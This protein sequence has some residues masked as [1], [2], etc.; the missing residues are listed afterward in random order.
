[1]NEKYQKN[2]IK[3]PSSDV[4]DKD[5]LWKFVV[6]ISKTGDQ[7][8]KAQLIESGSL[9]TDTENI[10]KRNLSYLKYLGIIEESREKIKKGDAKE[11][12]QKFKVIKSSQLVCDLMYELKA[13][14]KD[15]IAIAK[16]KWNTLIANHGLYKIL[17]NDFFKNES[18]KTI[19]DLEHFLR[20][21]TPDRRPAYYQ[22]GA[23]FLVGLLSDA[24]H[25]KE[26]DNKLVLTDSSMLENDA[27]GIINEESSDGNVDDFLVDVC[28]INQG[29]NEDCY[30]FQIK[31]P[32]MKNEIII[33]DEIDF[34]IIEAIMKKIRQ[35]IITETN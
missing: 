30:I 2:E 11:N 16:E 3:L 21:N 13:A 26:E 27:E 32:D 29:T 10:I 7:F 4:V 8:T 23:R 20:E 12:I 31:G 14:K 22:D 34:T 25:L 19:V 17:K 28:K 18:R 9:Y 35:K 24:N 33:K 5:S 1:M 6:A 15:D